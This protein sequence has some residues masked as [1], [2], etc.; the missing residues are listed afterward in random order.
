[1]TN[2]VAQTV[3]CKAAEERWRSAHNRVARYDAI[4]T[5]VL[6]ALAIALIVFI[7]TLVYAVLWADGTAVLVSAVASAAGGL[8]TLVSGAAWLA[9]KNMR[10][11]VVKEEDD[12]LD[13]VKTICGD[14]EAAA[15]IA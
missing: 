15:L 10:G 9:I 3:A 4:N 6:L 5:A 7:C 8:G 14:Q 12:A 2:L 1:M 11:E 13:D